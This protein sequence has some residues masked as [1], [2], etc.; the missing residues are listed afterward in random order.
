MSAMPALASPAGTMKLV[1]GDP[2]L[3]FV[4]TVGGR[5]RASARVRDDKL[6]SYTDLLAFARH[7]GLLE[8]RVARELGRLAERR[9][10]A[11]AQAHAR[12]L[13]WR[14]A[15]YRTLAALMLGRPP[16]PADLAA[17]EAEIALARGHEGL[18]HRNGALAWEWRAPEAALDSPLWPLC[19]AAAALIT[20]P[21]C[22]R[23][24]QCGG[25]DCGWLFLDQSRNH[26]RQWCT[27][28]DCGN[29][30][31]VRRFRARRQVPWRR[32]PDSLT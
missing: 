20:S 18:S 27:M 8:A 1:G 30:A 12:A 32:E 3:D 25:E 2:V 14:E 26:S 28:E 15:L 23:M 9:P 19:R 29:L 10:R 24:R 7:A 16:A 17:V 4:N 5:A 6:G 13:A 31:K 22:E 21:L 11:A